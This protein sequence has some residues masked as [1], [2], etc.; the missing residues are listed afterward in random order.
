MKIGIYKSS[1]IKIL[2]AICLLF[3][4]ASCNEN[5][6]SKLDFFVGTWK[7]EGKEQYEF[8]E[9]H[10]KGGLVGYS[11]KLVKHK[12]IISETLTIKNVG[13]HLVYGATVLNQNDG[14]TIEFILNPDNNE[15]LSF[16]NINHDFPKKIQYKRIDT[17]RIKVSVLGKNDKGFSYIQIKQPTIN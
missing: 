12:K 17:D 14:K 5:K 7:K 4:L 10:P 3:L 2:S 15:Y 13:D 1:N 11:Y 8:W 16:E 6:T 9:K